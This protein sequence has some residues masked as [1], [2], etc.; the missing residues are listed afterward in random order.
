MIQSRRKV[1]SVEGRL[2]W[3]VMMETFTEYASSFI[4]WSFSQCCWWRLKSSGK[5]ELSSG[6]SRYLELPG[7]GSR[8]LHF[9]CAVVVYIHLSWFIYSLLLW[10]KLICLEGGCS[11]EAMAFFLQWKTS[12]LVFSFVFVLKCVVFTSTLAFFHFLC[13]T[14]FV[15]VRCRE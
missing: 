9:T 5:W 4:V 3:K 11:L 15:S 14:E 6:Y 10:V 8:S 13:E 7:S 1:Y 12:V 2:H